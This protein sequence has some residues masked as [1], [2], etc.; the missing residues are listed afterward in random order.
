MH[1]EQEDSIVLLWP[2]CCNTDLPN[3]PHGPCYRGPWACLMFFLT[4]LQDNLLCMEK[5][6]S[7]PLPLCLHQEWVGGGGLSYFVIC[8]HRDM[9]VNLVTVAAGILFVSLRAREVRS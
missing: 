8:S 1:V 7:A 3:M 6:S 9:L 5:P 2:P 4:P